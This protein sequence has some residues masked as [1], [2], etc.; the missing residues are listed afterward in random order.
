[1]GEGN[2]QNHPGYKN[3]NRKNKEITKGNKTGDRKPREETMSHR[4]KHHQQNTID[5]R[6]NLRKRRYHRKH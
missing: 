4:C 2:E 6:E 3:G 5:R 1:M